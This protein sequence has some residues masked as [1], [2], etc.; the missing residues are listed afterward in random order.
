MNMP[1][2]RPSGASSDE[3]HDRRATP[4]LVESSESVM[5]VE[6]ELVEERERGEHRRAG[7]ASRRRDRDAS[8]W[9]SSAPSPVDTR[10][11]ASVTVS[12]YVGIAEEVHEPLDHRDLEEHEAEPERGEVHGRHALGRQR[13]PLPAHDEE[14]RSRKTR[15]VERRRS[16]SSRSSTR[17]PMTSSGSTTSSGSKMSREHVA[18]AARSARR[19]GASSVT[20]LMSRRVGGD[21]RVD[22][23]VGAAPRAGRRSLVPDGVPGRVRR[24]TCRA[25]S[26]TPS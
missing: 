10:I 14:R 21:D 22:L 11:D 15:G 3:R 7:P 9:L 23:G 13:A 5:R 2:H 18:E 19:T 1:R 8:R 17:S 4:R 16:P 24:L 20:A 6:R 12:E 26:A 25:A